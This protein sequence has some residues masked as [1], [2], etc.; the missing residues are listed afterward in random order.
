MF[1]D[2][3]E[4]NMRPGFNFI[5][6]EYI[7]K[8]EY[9]KIENK[10]SIIEFLK[11]LQNHELQKSEEIRVTGLTFLLFKSKYWEKI[12]S[13]IK[14]ILVNQVDY[15]QKKKPRVQFEIR[16]SLEEWRNIE[17]SYQSEEYQL[18]KIFGNL[19]YIDEGYYWQQLN[20]S[21]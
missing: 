5:D 20:V 7:K 17:I 13:L 15:L 8:K 16:G 19:D 10:I 21:S 4:I 9:E 1:K 6:E 18:N 12:G 14:N 2:L 11:K 3:A